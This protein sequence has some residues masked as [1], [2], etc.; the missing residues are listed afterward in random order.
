[1]ATIFRDRVSLETEAALERGREALG[2]MVS[3]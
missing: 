3:R 1:V 2:E